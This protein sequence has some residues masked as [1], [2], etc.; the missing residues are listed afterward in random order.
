MTP[1]LTPESRTELLDELENT[2][3]NV[4]VIGGGIAGAAIA[5][6]AAARGLRVA[7]C[8]SGDFGVGTSSR[9]SKL[10]H[11][12]LRYLAHGRFGF[13]R[14]TARERNM[15]RAMAPHLARP[16]WMVAPARHR[17][18][19][20]GFR[21]ALAV[22]ER[23]GGISRGDTH[24]S[25]DR[26]ELATREPSL[27]LACFGRAVA[28][29]EYLT[30]D[31]RLVLAVL[32]AAVESGAAV[33]SRAP[34]RELLR[35]ETRVSGVVAHCAVTG[36][37][38]SVDGDVVVNAAGPWVDR[39]AM[40]EAEPPAAQVTVS[41]GVHLVVDRSR[42]PVAH[43]ILCMASDRR[44]IF[45][46]PRGDIVYIGTTDTGYDGERVAWPAI[47]RADVDY[48]LEALGGCFT[49][50]PLRRGDVL[51]AWAGLRALPARGARKSIRMSREAEL[52]AGPGMLLSVSGGKLTGFAGLAAGTVELVS[53]IGEFDLGP[54]PGAA[55]LPGAALEPAV[56]DARLHQLYG[57]DAK[58]IVNLGG[59]SLVEGTPVV[60]GEVDW[61][62]NV[63]AATTVEDVIYRRT[64][65]A[66]HLPRHR[67]K[68][69]EAVADRMAHLLSWNDHQR[70][71]QVC[72]VKQRFAAELA[73]SGINQND[74]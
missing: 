2:H 6:D 25:W 14:R 40:L 23:L 31:V 66:W 43:P 10:I 17:M 39:L 74:G 63:E 5:R 32:R 16:C 69:A 26:A 41:K 34:V 36:R 13:V 38:V 12:G 65:A 18:Q 52:R 55:P 11:G 27:N 29:R 8:E 70:N 47:G 58:H 68:L 30:D 53:R 37:E 59:G 57:T 1:A 71:E 42:L 50:S 60:A 3:F 45:A 28:F 54:G 22:Y 21:C 15:V 46:I 72:A 51:A 61:A 4:I 19:A 20:R 44:W 33:C 56:D 48:L 49:T 73:F 7:L 24:R 64:L 62:V 9:S 35:H 67:L